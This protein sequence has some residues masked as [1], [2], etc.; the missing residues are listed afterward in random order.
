MGPLF[1]AERPTAARGGGIVSRPSAMV[2]SD[3]GRRRGPR[4]RA[5][6]SRGGAG[7]LHLHNNRLID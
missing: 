5:D 7:R 4:R 1:K 2:P 3:G 6:G